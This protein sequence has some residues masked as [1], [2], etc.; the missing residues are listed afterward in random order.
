MKRLF[1]LSLM[2]TASLASATPEDDAKA[3]VQKNLIAPLRA[4]E[5]RHSR[6]SRARLPAQVRRVRM[7]DSEPQK[8][9]QGLEFLTFTVDAKH[10]YGELDDDGEVKADSW[11][12]DVITGCV[13]PQS[14]EVFVKKGEKL[15]GAGLLLGKKTSAAAEH[16]CKAGGEQVAA[17]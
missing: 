8:D 11:R 1:A 17:K 15:F 4:K 13:Y 10:G 3:V 14:G 9:S 16:V 2:L 5:E 12:K 7:L 6:F